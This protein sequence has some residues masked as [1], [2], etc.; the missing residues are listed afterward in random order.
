LTNSIYGYLVKEDS[1]RALAILAVKNTLFKDLWEK[2]IPN[3][4]DALHNL[5]LSRQS[6]QKKED[7]EQSDC[8][9][10]N[11]LSKLLR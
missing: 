5:F 3:A 9:N 2:A 8:E 4:A 10:E 1:A 6:Q 7:K 11:D